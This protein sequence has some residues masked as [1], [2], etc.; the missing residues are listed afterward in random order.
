M[1]FATR[2][3]HLKPEGAYEVLAR[4]NQLEAAGKEIIHLEIGQPDYATFENVSKA[5]IEAI[6]TGKTRYTPPAGLPA[7]REAIAERAGRQR[8]I[9]VHPDEVVVSP[10]GK[11]NLF[12]PT[13]ALVEPGDEVIYPNPGF[14]TYEAMIIVAGGVPVAVPL[15]EQNQFSFDLDAFDG[16]INE[17]TKLIILNSP[18]NPTGGVIPS[19]D[20]EHI[21]SQAK[22]YGCWV[23]SDEIYAR[24]VYD[25]LEAPSI[26][27]LPGM[28]ERTIIVDGFSK[29]YSMT[30]WRLGFGIMP[31][32]LADKV[33]LLLTHSVGSTAHFTQ[34]AGL[35]AITGPQDMVGVLVSEYQRRRDAIV[36]GLNAI[37]G[38]VCQ[39]PQGAFYVFPNITGTGK[40]S[41]E[42][43]NLILEKAGVALL[44]GNSFGKY[45]EGYLR[46]SYAN[47]LENIEKGLEKIRTILK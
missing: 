8:G 3:N 44:S 7:L 10:G 13:L 19:T 42:L 46:I 31:K 1:S 4:A 24:L 14:P 26:A 38:F 36:E 17:K 35:E 43:A 22:R 30:G 37:P 11:P 20:L 27:T 25:G 23:M 40:E 28:K 12:F 47:S 9:E 29:T 6:R 34:F 5:G 21:A 15:L 33:D 39:N 45:G 16:L 2:T 18:S 41:S 32:E